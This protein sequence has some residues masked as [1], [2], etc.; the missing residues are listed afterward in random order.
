[1]CPRSSHP[2][3]DCIGYK[4]GVEDEFERKSDRRPGKNRDRPGSGAPLVRRNVRERIEILGAGGG[5]ILSSSHN[6][7]KA[8]PLGNILAM[9]DEATKVV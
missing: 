2:S 3:L 4:I 5:Y 7:L 9:Y 1:M 6:L 8:F